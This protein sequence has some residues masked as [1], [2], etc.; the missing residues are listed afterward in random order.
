MKANMKR[1]ALY[2]RV[3]SDEQAMRGLSLSAQKEA[4]HQYAHAN[5]Y[6]I[7]GLYADEGVTARKKYHNR[8]EFMRMLQDVK[9]GAIDL[10][11]F[12]KL[13][14]WFRNVSDYYEVQRILDA[15][16]VAWIATEE[17][18]DTT[19]ANGRLNLNIR[20]S[21][22]QDE[23]DRTAERIKFVFSDKV[24]RGEVISGKTPYGYKIQNKRLVIEPE[25]AALVRDIFQHYLD[26][27]S[28][29]ATRK[30]VLDTCGLYYT[31][32][33]LRMLLQNE[34]YIGRAHGMDDFCDPIIDK[35]QFDAVQALIAQRA[36]RYST[37]H[38]DRIYLF[39]S[40]VFCKE[41][42]NRLNGHVVAGKYVYYRC[43]KYEKLHQC[44]HQKRTS[45]LTLESRLLDAIGMQFKEH[46]TK[47]EFGSPRESRT[48]TAKIR[49]K[50]CKLK[51][52]YLNDLIELADYESNYMALKAALEAGAEAES[53]KPVDLSWIKDA[54]G[55][56]AKLDRPHKKAFWSRIAGRIT[57]DNEENIAIL[58]TQSLPYPK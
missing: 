39:S 4:L 1:A 18:Y 45:E 17:R 6:Q 24:R 43:G 33:G 53:Q 52:L 37:A 21:I 36:Q 9:A 30:Y 5:E 38:P 7:V 23:S 34:R 46:S 48:H 35:Q 22:A 2:I 10:I 55:C 51:D 50:M 28:V 42:G 25:R 11:L 12:I 29:R 16:N 19:T 14:R 49:A 54:P 3:S 56:Y 15:H 31:Q 8:A 32:A 40:I 13:D 20:L 57:I 58:P 27:R 47:I 26:V 41:C 44:S